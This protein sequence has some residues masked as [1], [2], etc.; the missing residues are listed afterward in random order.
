MPLGSGLRHFP[1]PPASRGHG[2]ELPSRGSLDGAAPALRDHP[3][4]GMEWAPAHVL[5][6]LP[7]AAAPTMNHK[8]DFT[9]LE[10]YYALHRAIDLHKHLE[11]GRLGVHPKPPAPPPCVPRATRALAPVLHALDRIGGDFC[12]SSHSTATKKRRGAPDTILP[13]VPTETPSEAPALTRTPSEAKLFKGRKSCLKLPEVQRESF[14]DNP[15]ERHPRPVIGKPQDTASAL[16]G[17]DR[18]FVDWYNRELRR[19]LNIERQHAAARVRLTEEAWL[20]HKASKREQEQY[21]LDAQRVVDRKRRNA[22]MEKL[23]FR[24]RLDPAVAEAFRDA[25]HDTLAGAETTNQQGNLQRDTNTVVD[26]AVAVGASGVRK[27]VDPHLKEQLQKEREKKEIRAFLEVPCFASPEAR[28]RLSHN[29]KAYRAAAWWPKINELDAISYWELVLDLKVQS[30]AEGLS[31]PQAD[32]RLVA[33]A[34]AIAARLNEARRSLETPFDA[35]ASRI[36]PVP[37]SESPSPEKDKPR[38]YGRE[39]APVDK[40]TVSAGSNITTPQEESSGELPALVESRGA[41]EALNDPEVCGGK[42]KHEKKSGVL[43]GLPDGLCKKGF[44]SGY[45]ATPA[46]VIAFRASALAV[47]SLGPFKLKVT[48]AAYGE[49][50]THHRNTVA[51]DRAVHSREEAHSSRVTS[52][53]ESRKFASDDATHTRHTAIGRPNGKTGYHKGATQNRGVPE[54]KAPKSHLLKPSEGLDSPYR[55]ESSSMAASTAG[56]ERLE[57]DG[58]HGLEVASGRVLQ[59]STVKGKA[60]LKRVE[61]SREQDGYTIA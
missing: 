26:T 53:G 42:R 21:R 55:L 5:Q 30:L 9:L 48:P 4:D 14:Q 7:V 37:L 11:S 43:L 22:Y 33:E 24:L 19:K 59:E 56:A 13:S 8:I 31:A 16:E 15:T 50:Q 10:R 36:A 60:I 49:R 57:D 39:E 25:S 54:K 46:D 27:K 45:E 61:D 28:P 29:K 18:T 52:R 17:F 32:R 34:A 41:S 38:V 44:K 20:E 58:W 12:S 23:A 47:R 3:I 6:L 40:G 35:K 51:T 2:F 1:S